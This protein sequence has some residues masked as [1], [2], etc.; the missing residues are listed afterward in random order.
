VHLISAIGTLLIIQRI[1]GASPNLIRCS[2]TLVSDVRRCRYSGPLDLPAPGGYLRNQHM[3]RTWMH[4]RHDE[5]SRCGISNYS[6]SNVHR[7]ILISGSTV[8][9]IASRVCRYAARNCC[10]RLSRLSFPAVSCTRKIRASCDRIGCTNFPR[11]IA[12]TCAL[13]AGTVRAMHNSFS[14]LVFPVAV[15][16]RVCITLHF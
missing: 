6:I 3:A 8:G 12:I 9:R 15:S 10:T 14:S 16:N 4:Q 2:K 13:T 11:Q 7:N 1:F 5:L